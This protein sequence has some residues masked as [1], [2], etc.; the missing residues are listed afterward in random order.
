[1]S[2]LTDEQLQDF[3]Q[4]LQ[5]A[6]IAMQALLNQTAEDS[7]PVDL[8]LPIGRLTRIDAIQSQA[9]AQMN[10]HQLE[11][12]LKQVDAALMTFDQ[13]TYGI[14]RRCKDPV[15]LGRLEVL[16][17]SPFCVDCQESFEQRR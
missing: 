10:R 13:G 3:Q 2:H 17:E 14:C 9:M 8:D 7:Q 11:I 1:M 12:R 4:R 16:P 15:N 5:D 6:K